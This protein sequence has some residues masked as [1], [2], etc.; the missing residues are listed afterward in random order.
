MRRNLNA[1][2]LI[3]LL[4]VIAI[5]AILAAILFPVFA[6]AKAAAKKTACLSNLRQVGNALALYAGDS[7]DLSPTLLGRLQTSPDLYPDGFY[8]RDYYVQLMPYAKN[9]DLFFCPDRT[10]YSETDDFNCNDGYNVKSR[11][12]GYGYNWGF[13]ADSVTGLISGREVSEDGLW[14]VDLGKSLSL[15]E[16]PSSMFAFADTGDDSRYTITADY[17]FQNENGDRNSTL[18]HG[19]RLNMNFVDGH[20]GNIAFRGAD[21]YDEVLG[22]PA[23]R[24]QAL[25]YC[26]RPDSVETNLGEMTCAEWV[27]STYDQATV[28]AD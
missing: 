15:V 5:I 10:E 12:I 19:G 7:D 1:F 18:R 23:N 27:E 2:T 28:W 16:A 3:E 11:C 20:A 9:L 14:K 4:V 24:K 8:E 22:L 26:D 17:I 21:F 25:M 6:Q 13:R